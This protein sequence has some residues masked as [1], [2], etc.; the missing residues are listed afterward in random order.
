M[1]QQG[2]REPEMEA[3]GCGEEVTGK[4]EGRPPGPQE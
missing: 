2:T 4:R 3:E 1:G